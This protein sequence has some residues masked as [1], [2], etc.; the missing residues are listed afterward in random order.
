MDGK[1][2]VGREGRVETVVV[3]GH[4]Q[5]FRKRRRVGFLTGKQGLAAVLGIG[6]GNELLVV[7]AYLR[8]D[9]L[10]V[11]RGH[12][13]GARLIGQAFDARNQGTHRGQG[14][15]FLGQPARGLGDVRLVLGELTQF[16][17][18]IE[19]FH[20]ARGIV[21][22]LVDALFRGLL[23]VGLHQGEQGRIGLGN[24]LAVQ[25]LLRDAHDH[26]GLRGASSSCRGRY[27]T[28]YPPC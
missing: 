26:A 2:A 14:T 8:G 24:H 19:H 10:P 22:R 3:G 9:F 18:Q 4:P 11:G 12:G 1:P 5:A 17:A 27:R 6:Q 16:V 7:L 25:A 28:G 20:R 15:I 21:G 23:V 13:A